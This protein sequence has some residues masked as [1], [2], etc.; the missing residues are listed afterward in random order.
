MLVKIW[1]SKEV[2]SLLAP[3]SAREP[4]RAKMTVF[5]WKALEASLDYSPPVSNLR[6]NFL[7][8]EFQSGGIF[9]GAIN[10]WTVQPRNLFRKLDTRKRIAKL[11]QYISLP[12]CHCP[13]LPL[14]PPQPPKLLQLL[15]NLELKK[16]ASILKQDSFHAK[17]LR[18]L[19]SSYQISNLEPLRFLKPVISGP[20][21]MLHF[22]QV[23]PTADP[24]I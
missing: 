1:P 3:G 7:W 16:F 6:K 14:L 17:I 19:I 9:F 21:R 10:T 2:R 4:L 22:N 5:T 8:S 24:I 12:S 11:C 23:T 18:Y 20:I 13:P 15:L